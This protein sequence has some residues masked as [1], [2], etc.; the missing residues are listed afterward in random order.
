M[1]IAISAAL[2]MGLS[3]MA[4]AWAQSKIGTAGAVSL[5]EKPEMSA[6]V[7]ILIASP[8]TFTILGLGGAMRLLLRGGGCPPPARRSEPWAS[9]P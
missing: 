7:I 2:V 1:W 5:A 8:E 4:T 3:A 9:K 6:T